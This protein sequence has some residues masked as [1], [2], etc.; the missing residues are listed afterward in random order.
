MNKKT[1]FYPFLLV[2][3]IVIIISFV[4]VRNFTDQQSDGIVSPTSTT[5]DIETGT[6]EIRE[7]VNVF[8]GEQNNYSDPQFAYPI[9]NESLGTRYG[10]TLLPEL[11]GTG[12]DVWSLHEIQTDPPPW[13]ITYES[14]QF[15][16]VARALTSFSPD[17]RYLAFRTRWNLGLAKYDFRLAVFDLQNGETII[18]QPPEGQPGG[19]IYP[20]I[21]SYEWEGNNKMNITVYSVESEYISEENKHNYYRVTP[22]KLWQYD[23]ETREYTF[24][25]EIIS[26][27]QE[28]DM[29]ITFLK[30]K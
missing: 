25:R 3:G 1:Y 30:E 14:D 27:I 17:N 24:L 2:L 4:Y 21:E 11:G 7:P 22:K 29:V 9:V 28:G 18:I 6:K 5:T 8:E 12:G 23:L 10:F 19:F 13:K 26:G 15:G 20:Y 16:A